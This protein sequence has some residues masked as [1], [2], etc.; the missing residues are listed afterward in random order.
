MNP[1]AEELNRTIQASSPYLFEMLSAEGKR[2]YYPSKG[3][4]SQ[5]AEAKQHAHAHNATIGVALRD[6]KAMYLPS[7][8]DQ[9]PGIDPDEALLYAPSYGDLE[10]RKA[11]QTVTLHDNPDLA[12]KAVSLP[13]VTGGLS[14][15]LSLIADLVVDEGDLL[16]YPDK[17]WGNYALNFVQR[18]GAQ[19][20]LFPFLDGDH[21]NTNAFRQALAEIVASGRKKFVTLLN[22]P[23]NPTG[24]SP[25]E[26]E[27][28][29]IADALKEVADQG[30]NVV[31][32]VDDAYY[33]LF[34]DAA[35]A[36]QSLFT[37]LAGLHPRILA[38][39]A[40]AATK[41]VYVWGLRVGFV[42]F[43][44]GGVKPGDPVFQALTDKMGGLVRAVVS[45][46]SQLSQHV[47]AKALENPAFYAERAANVELIGK[48]A[49]KVKEVLSNPKYAEAWEVYPFNSGYFMCLKI[50]KVSAFDLRVHLLQKY[51]T[52]T[53]AI[54]DTDLRIAFSS[55]EIEQIPDL[56]ELTFQAWKDLVS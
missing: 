12:G 23:N 17:N 5:S 4:L 40:D 48:R 27:C 51:G 56:Y 53:I 26:Q 36:R 11:W 25:T 49:A 52:G 43:S 54:N 28:Q 32:I 37:K 8:M 50:K 46:C 31:V 22:F 6:G 55:V 10:L 2:F 30:I 47:V 24:Y 45:N 9:L 42:A 15:G 44:I 18:K 13:V 20:K 29:D 35:V 19:P 7:V 21:F 3:I 41:E 34:F 16:L 14:H 1:L 39:K 33:G 38:F